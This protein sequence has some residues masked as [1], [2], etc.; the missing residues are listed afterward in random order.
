LPLDVVG[1]LWNALQV[2]NQSAVETFP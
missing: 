2:R 1:A